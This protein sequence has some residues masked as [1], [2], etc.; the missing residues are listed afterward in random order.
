MGRQHKWGWVR[1]EPGP[2]NSVQTAT[3]VAG[4]QLLEPPPKMYMNGKVELGAELVL[5]P[6]QAL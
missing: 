3:Q 5:R 4:T 2:G 1:P 6:R